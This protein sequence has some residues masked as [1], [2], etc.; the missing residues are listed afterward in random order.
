MPTVMITGAGRGLGLE[1]A[2]EYAA[3][4]WI[5]IATCREPTGA[6]ELKKLGGKVEIVSIDVTDF[7]AIR[8]LNKTLHERPIDV[9]INNAGVIGKDRNLGE[10]DGD[11]WLETLRVNTVAPILI[12]QALLPNLR[13]GKDKKAI[14]LT[15]LMGSIADNSSGRY[16]DYRSSKAGLNAAV[17]SFAIDTKDDGITA[18]VIHPG[19]VKTDMGGENAPTEI[20]ASVGG[21]RKVIAGLK[22]GDSGGF[23]GHDGRK[24]AW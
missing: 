14:F 6:T 21:M 22:A 9:L 15:S 7:T 3:E 1:F 24:L 18:I 8:S 11:R 19:W 2:R 17:K 16:Y 20:A 12:A 10:L 23:F 13:A 5:V 4:G